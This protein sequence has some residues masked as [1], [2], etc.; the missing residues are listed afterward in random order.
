[1]MYGIAWHWWI[2]VW[3]KMKQTR[4]K[5][6]RGERFPFTSMCYH[7]SNRMCIKHLDADNKQKSLHA[8]FFKC[9]IFELKAKEKNLVYRNLLLVKKN[10]FVVS[11]PSLVS[12]SLFLLERFFIYLF[13]W[14]VCSIARSIHSIC[15]GVLCPILPSLMIARGLWMCETTFVLLRIRYEILR[16]EHFFCG[17]FNWPITCCCCCCHHCVLLAC[18]C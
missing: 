12:F 9:F 16:Y 5:N 11:F 14:H 8:L 1:M 17:R 13:L 6:E 3:M 10:Q 7:N 18:W 15:L 4:K 2:L